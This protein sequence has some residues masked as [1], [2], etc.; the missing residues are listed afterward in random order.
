MRLAAVEE[1]GEFGALPGGEASEGLAGGDAAVGEG[2][3]GAGGAD[4]GDAQEQVAHL[5]AGGVCGR[6]VHDVSEVDPPVGDVVFELG[7]GDADGVGVV[8]RAQPLFP[9]L[10]G[11]PP[12]AVA[13]AVG[14]G[15]GL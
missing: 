12:I 7:A 9:R 2:A 10:G 11:R 14:R 15:A 1:V 13:S 5:G 6:V 3:V 4:A 8:E